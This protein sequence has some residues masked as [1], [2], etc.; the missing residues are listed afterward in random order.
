MKELV[1][2]KVDLADLSYSRN[3]GMACLLRIVG[4]ILGWLVLIA[5]DMIVACKTLTTN[6]G[7]TS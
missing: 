3:A 7:V 6:K 2:A 4:I 1:L 5:G